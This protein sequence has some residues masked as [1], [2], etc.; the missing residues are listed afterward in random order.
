LYSGS[1]AIPESVWRGEGVS[2]I[3]TGY[4]IWAAWTHG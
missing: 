3:G 2:A 4:E 1:M